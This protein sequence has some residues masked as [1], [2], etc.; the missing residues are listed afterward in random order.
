MSSINIQQK[1]DWYN[2]LSSLLQ[3]DI[4][5]KRE[6][7]NMKALKAQK[8]NKRVDVY[9]E[10]E[11]LHFMLK[12]NGYGMDLTAHIDPETENKTWVFDS[13][14]YLSKNPSVIGWLIDMDTHWIC[15]RKYRDIWQE[16]ISSTHF[17]DIEPYQIINKIMSYQGTAYMIWKLWIPIQ[18]W[19]DKKEPFY[20]R[21]PSTANYIRW[22]YEPTSCWLGHKMNYNGKD[23]KILK[24]LRGWDGNVL[25]SNKKELVLCK[26]TD[27]GWDSD[28]IME[29]DGLPLHTQSLRLYELAHK[30]IKI[31]INNNPKASDHIYPIL[32]H[33]L[34]SICN[35][36]NINIDHKQLS[37]F[38]IEDEEILDKVKEYDTM[39]TKIYN[40]DE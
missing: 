3:N 17:K 28:I 35:K 14:T 29:F 19:I 12:E 5:S 11:I 31:F 13:I 26:P 18:K 34:V 2:A 1:P 30:Q 32:A 37:A 27:Q 6:F 10:S 25:M 4:F 24:Q 15:I 40:K 21:G 7:Q 36:F 20:I 38:N 16:Q 39:L 23:K 9:K 33:S 22:E 8:E